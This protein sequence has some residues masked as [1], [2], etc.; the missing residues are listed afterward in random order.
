MPWEQLLRQLRGPFSFLSS[1][2]DELDKLPAAYGRALPRPQRIF[3]DREETTPIIGF[4][5]LQNESEQLLRTALEAY[6]DAEEELEWARITRRPNDSRGY[7]LAW[8][9]YSRLLSTATENVTSSSFGRG[10]PSIFWLYH[11]IAVSRQLK[12]V[13]RRLVRRSSDLARLHGD[14]VKYRIYQRYLDRVVRLTYDV[15]QEVA[16]QAQDREEELFPQLLQLMRDN[17]LILSEDHIGPDLAELGSYFRGYLRVEPERVRNAVDVAAH[18]LD[19]RLDTEPALG[20]ALRLLLGSELPDDPRTLLTRSELLR[21]LSSWRGFPAAEVPPEDVDLWE[22]LLIRL[23]EFE[24]LA[25]LRRLAVPVRPHPTRGLVCRGAFWSLTVREVAVSDATRP[26]DFL[27]PWVVD[28]KVSRFG[29]IYDIS[30]FSAVLSVL[31]RSGVASQDSS[32][33]QI[34]R[35]QRRVNRLARRQRLRLEKYLGDGALYSG[36]HP[37]RLITVA[38]ELQRTYQQAIDEGFPFDRGMR[39]ALNYGT[40]RLLPIEGGDSSGGQLRYEFFG[41]GIVELSRLVTGKTMRDIDETK[42]L[43]ISLGYPAIE[44]DQFFAPVTSQNVDLINKAEENR[45]FYAYINSSG[46]LINEGIVATEKFVRHLEEREQP[47]PVRRVREGRRTYVVSEIEAGDETVRVALRR[48]GKASFKGI[49][50][51][52]VYEVVDT[53]DWAEDRGEPLDGL[54]LTAALDEAVASS[55]TA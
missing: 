40:Y 26:L 53:H 41:Q 30:D 49:G 44:V 28:P 5:I 42:T 43:L 27:R 37:A 7:Q 10:Y 52:V 32:F 54:T 23:K 20:S 4:P 16:R 18:W 13:P 45:P 2:P 11:S 8:E 25:G 14:A 55:R 36:R 22:Q 12:E 19:A 35:F 46:A 39:I 24:L 3:L 50:K 33:R 9:E 34:F 21:F 31:G 1:D 6:L 47:V 48:L 17:V 38:L 15:V 29:L 51:L